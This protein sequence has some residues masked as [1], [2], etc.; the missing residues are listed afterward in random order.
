MMVPLDGEVLAEQSLVS[1]VAARREDSLGRAGAA[2]V[3]VDQVAVEKN[4]QVRA[5]EVPHRD[6]GLQ[7]D[8]LMLLL[9]EVPDVP[10]GPRVH[11]LPMWLHA[12]GGQGGSS[13][14]TGWHGSAS[15]C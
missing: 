2:V 13:R 7:H 12:S 10:V 4:L 15:A 8:P 9:R 6:R 5:V 11:R 14:G 1:S 3:V